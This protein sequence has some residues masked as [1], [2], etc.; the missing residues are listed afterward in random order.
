MVQIQSAIKTAILEQK[1]TGTKVDLILTSG[2]TGF[3]TDDVTP[4]AVEAL[5]CRKADVLN[6]MMQ[7]EALKVTPLACLS[8]SVIGMVSN[9]DEAGNETMV[10]TLPGKP[11]AVKENFTILMK[12]RVLAHALAH[13]RNEERH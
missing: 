1:E 8:R 4:E 6:Q 10:I 5:L 13:L 11:K 12:N 7:A 2:G 3:T 9:E